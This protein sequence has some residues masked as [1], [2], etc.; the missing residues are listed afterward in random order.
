MWS[1]KLSLSQKLETLVYL[2]SPITHLIAMAAIALWT[3]AAILEPD[4]TLD[5]WLG[6]KTF[7]TLMLS[8]A[9]GPILSTITAIFRNE[10]KERIIR[11]ILTIP[12]TLTLITANLITNSKGA[13]EGILRNDL[14]FEKT[15]KYGLT[16]NTTKYEVRG[17][18]KITNLIKRNIFEFALSILVAI[19]I[20]QV[21]LKGQISTTIPL[22]F[23]LFSWLISVFQK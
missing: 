2:S 8:M 13:I 15:T 11:K 19:A 3:L 18:Q 21:I 20:V 7:S 4:A 22:A 10:R 16:Q 6:T 17:E 12:L 9:T 14:A 23:I 5:L 1:D